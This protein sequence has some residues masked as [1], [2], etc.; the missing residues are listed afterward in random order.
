MRLP[1]SNRHKITT[2]FNDQKTRLPEVAKESFVRE[3]LSVGL[4]T[5]TIRNRKC[6]EGPKWIATLIKRRTGGG[7]PIC[8]AGRVKS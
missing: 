7:C 6:S 2:D 8:P 4:G 5:N 3:S 1:S